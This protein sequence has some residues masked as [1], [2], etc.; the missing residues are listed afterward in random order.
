MTLTLTAAL[1]IASAVGTTAPGASPEFRPDL[2]TL[3]AV[4]R[5]ELPQRAVEKALEQAKGQPYQYA[6]PVDLEFTPRQGLWLERGGTASW[7][8]V[9]HSR[10]ATSLSLHL[11]GPDLPPGARVWTYDSRGRRVHGPYD[12][13]RAASGG[14][15]TPPVAGDELVVEVRLPASR[16][17]A[18]RLGAAKAFHGFRGWTAETSA[19]NCNIDITCP[20]AAAWT[21]E[22][23]SVARISI[24]GQFLCTGQLLNNVNQ[25]Q[26]RLFLT[27]DHCGIGEDGGP[28]SSVVFYFDYTGPCGNNVSDPLPAP[29]FQ[30]AVRLAH[31]VQADFALLEITDPAP[32]PA[33]AYFAGWDATGDDSS[34]TASGAAIHHPSGDE[35]KIAFHA[36]AAARS[37]IDI[38]A[39][40]TIPAW[41]VTWAS[42]TTEPGSSGGGLWNS[43]HRVIGTL[44]GGYA[45]CSM[46]LEP[47]YFAR[48]DRAWTARAASD[49]QLRAH[50]DPDGTCVASVPGLDPDTEPAPGPVAPT[51]QNMVCLGARSTCTGKR[52]GGGG[53]IGA[54]ALATLLIGV[55]VRRRACSSAS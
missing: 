44:S 41:M 53:A 3:Q 27:A 24:G 36:T 10:G 4:P 51:A 49:G 20:Q 25:D 18:L 7:R 37:P 54:L 40:C 6:V 14:L 33:N 12:A 39:G 22:A 23:G 1:L 29:T 13:A 19:G 11:A 17:G 47:D 35:K 5:F 50:L 46:P 42:G 43:D 32:L 30:G 45:S 38:G 52:R 26:R 34:A 9:I 48:L 31:D 15:W 2:G 21:E 8:L 28:A 55:A 16:A